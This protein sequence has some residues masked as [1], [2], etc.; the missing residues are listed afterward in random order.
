LTGI[1]AVVKQT[2]EA[3]Q[4]GHTG[5]G[6]D[7]LGTVTFISTATTFIS[8]ATT[9]DGRIG[10]ASAHHGR[11]ALKFDRSIEMGDADPQQRFV[12]NYSARFGGVLGSLAHQQKIILHHSK[13][14]PHAA[15]GN[16]ATGRHGIAVELDVSLP[17]FARQYRRP[18]QGRCA[19][20]CSP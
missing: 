1:L 9:K 14:E 2:F 3:V 10:R 16:E 4:L 8:T 13:A 5:T 19:T 20:E 11:I 18:G 12:C 17:R 7:M 6:H 15:F